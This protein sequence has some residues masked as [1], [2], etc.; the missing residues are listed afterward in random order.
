MP[1]QQS[2]PAASAERDAVRRRVRRFYKH[3]NEPNPEACFDLIDPRLRD[4][5]RVDF[6]Q[7]GALPLAFLRAYGAV[8]I[9]YTRISLHPDAGENRHDPRPFASV[10][11]LW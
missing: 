2:R 5:Q 11:V 6:G 8:T 10:Y 9:W 3:F 1:T 7:Y 4:R